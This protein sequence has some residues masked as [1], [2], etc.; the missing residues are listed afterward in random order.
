[1][2]DLRSSKLKLKLKMNVCKLCLVPT[3]MHLNVVGDAFTARASRAWQVHSITHGL[4]T[5][6]EKYAYFSM[7]KPPRPSDGAVVRHMDDNTA[8]TRAA[9]LEW[10]IRSDN[11]GP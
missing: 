1:M 6:T 8:D 9:N 5:S 3:T 4:D 7:G 10:G 2:L 11:T